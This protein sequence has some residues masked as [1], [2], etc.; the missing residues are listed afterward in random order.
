MQ[1]TAGG[2]LQGG[3]YLLNHPL[4]TQGFGITYR[5]TQTQTGQSVVVK[6]LHPALHGSK[7]FGRLRDRFVDVGALMT[8][9]PH[10]SL[11][12]VLDLFQ[13]EQLPFMVMEYVAGTSLAEMVT[14]DRPM[15]ELEALHYMRLVGGAIAQAHRSKLVH[16]NLKPQNI[17]RRTGG[18]TP[19]VVGYGIS[20]DR[21]L[22]AV[23]YAVPGF[24]HAFTAPEQIG[25]KGDRLPV[26]DLYGLAAN[27]YFLLTGHTPP[28]A[29]ERLQQ[30]RLPHLD[31]VSPMMQR[32][33]QQGM[34]LNLKHRSPSLEHWL[35]LLPSA[36]QPRA[37]ATPRATAAP[38]AIAATQIPAPVITPMPPTVTPTAPTVIEPPER[39]KSAPP[40][41]VVARRPEP[42]PPRLRQEP[43]PQAV[44][45]MPRYRTEPIAVQMELELDSVPNMAVQ[46]YS[47][48]QTRFE[49]KL[50]RSK[51]LNQS[52][53][54]LNFTPRLRRTLLLTGLIAT[55]IGG[56][57]GLALRFSAARAPN[58]GS[59]FHA[60]QAFPE[61]D[62]SGTLTPA[63]SGDSPIEA[64]PANPKLPQPK[65]SP[66]FNDSSIIDQPTTNRIATP[67]KAPEAVTLPEAPASSKRRDR[68]E[69][70]PFIPEA[71]PRKPRRAEPIAPKETTTEVAPEPPVGDRPAAPEAAP[72]KPLPKSPV[73]S[74]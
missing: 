51:S 42:E 44:V 21:M 53:G 62:W 13:E 69:D 29:S 67:E 10:A 6:T 40:A 4:E 8:K 34:A 1:L 36:S 63:D 5:A 12:K 74:Q 52:D 37:K 58:G 24:P 32:V 28:S 15:A 30:D 61:R 55:A 23:Q 70:P 7:A 49:E 45:G 56:S 73:K 9:S 48:D 17:L 26:S 16:G 46:G 50:G 27:L 18:N 41:P 47:P 68:T 64:P 14:P 31:R 35:D 65:E 60:G 19:V 71:A 39:P 2:L 54:W 25:E 57:F 59:M 20:A 33:L 72:T 43:L 3:K 11:V 22:S 66:A 38:E